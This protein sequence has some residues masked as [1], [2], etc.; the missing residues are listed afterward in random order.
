M[1]TITNTNALEQARALTQ[2][3]REASLNREPSV[4]QFW[5]SNR[6]L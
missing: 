5:N 3:T 4:S 2:P 1:K 6:K